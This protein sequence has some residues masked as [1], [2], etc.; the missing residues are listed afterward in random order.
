MPYLPST[1]AATGSIR[2]AL[3][4]N[5]RMQVIKKQCG[6]VMCPLQ[7][8]QG[9]CIVPFCQG[10]N[11]DAGFTDHSNTSTS[12]LRH[13]HVASQSMPEELRGLRISEEGLLIDEYTGKTVNEFGATRFDV[14]VRALRGDL[15]PPYWLDDS[16]QTPGVLLGSLFQFPADHVFHIV[17]K[18]NGDS[19]AFV[20]SVLSTVAL[21]CEADIDRDKTEVKARLG[22]KYTSV[23]VEV[24][25]RAPEVIYKVH[26]ELPDW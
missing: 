12:K 25:V 16:E 6:M 26:E 20:E 7:L 18:T 19:V 1:R 5:L 11:T 23:N 21:V 2:P 10:G 17:G 15:D 8:K 4:H 13:S 14:A 24:R 9:S 3:L 22:G